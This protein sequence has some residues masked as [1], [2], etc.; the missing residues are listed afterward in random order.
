M[1]VLEGFHRRISWRIAGK[2]TRQVEVD[3]W[4]LLPCGDDLGGGETVSYEGVCQ[5]VPGHHL[6]VHFHNTN[7]WA[8]HWGGAVAEEIQMILWYDQ[9]HSWAKGVNV[10]IIEELGEVQ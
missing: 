6:G 7:Q 10:F 5:A 8:V 2:M 3:G 4:E 9:D 1:K